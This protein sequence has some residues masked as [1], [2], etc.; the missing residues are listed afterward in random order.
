MNK[1][2]FID[3]FAGAGGLNEGFISAGFTP[4]AHVEMD[5]YASLTLKTRQ[6]FHYLKKQK[7]LSKYHDYLNKCISREVL[8]EMIPQKA[9]NSVITE[10]ISDRTRI[11]IFNRIDEMIPGKDKTV[12]LIIGGPPCQSYSLIGRSV[13]GKKINKDPRNLLFIQY[14][15][16][17]EKYRPKMFVFEN[18]PGILTAQNGAIFASIKEAFQKNGYLMDYKILNSND[19]G[20]LQNRKRVIIIGWQKNT[21]IR[22]PDLE[23]IFYKNAL[24][25]DILKDL[26]PLKQG[27]TNNVYIKVPSDYLVQ[28]GIR[29]HNDVLTLH[30]CRNNRESDIE[31][32]RE[33]IR[34]WNE[35]KKRLKYTD[36]PETLCFHKNRKVFLDRF[37]VLAG[38][39][40]AAQTLTA[41]I[42][43]DGHYFIH[44]DIN[45]SR[46]ISMREAARIQSFP[47]NYFFEGP[48][49]SVFTQIGNAVPPLMAKGIAKGIKNRLNEL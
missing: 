7:N 2:T 40:P 42:S 46:S 9:I 19:F 37:K 36:L 11:D 10:E 18:V 44:P 30:T 4:V 29:T 1:F 33:T 23:R 24:V 12:D 48:R 34:Y 15:K 38:D 21:S 43:K 13:V 17:L 20:V 6:C 22:Y 27:Q 8:Y 49:T 3:L 41:H 47:D 14:V 35:K 5:V 28:T 32:Y 26:S 39:L 31:I 16:F 45:Q 25:D